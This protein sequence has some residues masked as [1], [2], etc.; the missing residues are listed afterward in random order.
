MLQNDPTPTD[1]VPEI[2]SKRLGDATVAP[3]GL[4][5]DG[6]AGAGVSAGNKDA[7]VGVYAIAPVSD[8]VS[9]SLK[10]MFGFVFNWRF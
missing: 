1:P 10:L 6:L 5:G 2:A 9:N 8:V 3:S 7:D 4:S